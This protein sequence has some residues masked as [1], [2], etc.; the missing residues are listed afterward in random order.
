MGR[1]S[2]LDAFARGAGYFVLDGRPAK[3]I[4]VPLDP[5]QRRHG[6]IVGIGFACRHCPRLIFFFS[7]AS[8]HK[9]FFRHT[10]TNFF[11]GLALPPGGKLVL[12]TRYPY[13]G[14]P[15]HEVPDGLGHGRPAKPVNCLSAT[16]VV[17]PFSLWGLAVDTLLGV[18]F[19]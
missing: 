18:N 14:V 8:N 5:N 13:L 19:F 11:A 1:C 15:R 12:I 16:L 9:L 3:N 4:F 17:P 2:R 7:S 6:P 10:A